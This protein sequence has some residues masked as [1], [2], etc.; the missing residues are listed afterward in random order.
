MNITVV[1]NTPTLP[2]KSIR[3]PDKNVQEWYLMRSLKSDKYCLPSIPT[4]TY[5]KLPCLLPLQVQ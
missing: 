4:V 5:L 1:S 3:A 2:L